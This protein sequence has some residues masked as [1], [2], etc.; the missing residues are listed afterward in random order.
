ML[1]GIAA[2]YLTPACCASLYLVQ[3]Q[4]VY[5]PDPCLVWL[6]AKIQ[7][8][9]VEEAGSPLLCEMQLPGVGR[10]ERRVLT[11]P[12]LLEGAADGSMPLPPRHLEVPG[13][14][15]L[16]LQS[17]SSLRHIHVRSPGRDAAEGRRFLEKHTR[18]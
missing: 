15:T 9:A 8:I 1:S 12:R 2:T 5:V 6:P 4:N 18:S 17:T 14:D 16:L 10:T 7:G 13:E 11:L 3:R